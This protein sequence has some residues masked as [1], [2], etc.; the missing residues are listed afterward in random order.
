V[1]KTSQDLTEH[2]SKSNNKFKHRIK[3]LDGLRAIAIISVA[4]HHYYYIVPNKYEASFG[5]NIGEFFFFKHGWFGVMLFF[6]ISGFVITQTL[7]S[8]KTPLHFISKRFAR[9]FPTMLIC[10]I[11]TFTISF[12]EPRMYLSNFYNF[13][14]SLTFLDPRIFNGIFGVNDFNWMDGV[15]WTLF[16]EVRFY[17]IVAIIYFIDKSK[18]FRNFVIFASLIG[19]IFPL[20]IYFEIHQVRSILNFTLIA[21]YLPWFIFG[22]GCYYLYYGEHKKAMLLSVLSF[23]SLTLYILAISAKPYMPFNAARTFIGAAIIFV[24]LICSIKIDFVG[25]ILSYRPLTMIGVAS[26]SLYLLHNEIG[27][28]LIRIIDSS[29]HINSMLISYI[30]PALVLLAIAIF[31]LFLYKYYEHP[32]NR[33]LNLFFNSKRHND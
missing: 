14:P 2:K 11:I 21:S 13:L 19:I 23:I 33:K 28:K 26:Y 22:I 17:A 27:I 7:H 20:V 8:S 4:F 29:Q 24:L 3:Y 10:S 32:V 30:L 15:Y 25:R 31:S 5:K 1:I 9:L 16:T 6:S 18:F 12:I